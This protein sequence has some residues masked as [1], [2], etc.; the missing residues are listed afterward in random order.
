M[1][2]QKTLKDELKNQYEILT[3]KL[4]QT[5]IETLKKINALEQKL[6]RN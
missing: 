2:D 4:Q 6:E 1:S 5:E 3:E